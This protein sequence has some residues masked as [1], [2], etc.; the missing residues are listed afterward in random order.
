MSSVLNTRTDRYGGRRME[1]RTRLLLE[2][3]DAVVAEF[4]PGRVG[5]RLSPFGKYGSM[6]TD[7][8]VEETFLYL[9]EQLGRRGV[10]YIHLLYE[11]MPDA[12]M[13][14]AEFKPRYLDHALLPRLG[15][16]FVAPSSGAVASMTASAPR[17]R[18]TPD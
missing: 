1:D 18:S 4:G 16:H 12:N 15:R 10:A 3:V 11:L 13:E 5:V 17:L 7:P 8:L 14:M 6:P 2:V 9:A